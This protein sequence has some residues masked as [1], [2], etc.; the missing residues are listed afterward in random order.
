MEASQVKKAVEAL[1]DYTEKVQAQ[2]KKTALLDSSD[3]ISVQF[4]F[5]TIPE[6]ATKKPT[7]IRLPHPL[8]STDNDAKVCLIVKDPQRKVKDILEGQSKES[9]V[10]KVLGLSKLRKRY[11]QYDDKKQLCASYDVFLADEAV[12][13]MLAQLTGKAFFSCKKMPIPIDMRTKTKLLK[14]IE[15]ARSSTVFYSGAG[16]CSSVKAATTE[17]APEQ[18]AENIEGVVAGVVDATPQKWKNI[19]SIHVKTH[20]SVALPLYDSNASQDGSRKRGADGEEG[21]T[22][23]AKKKRRK[24]TKKA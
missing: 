17:F 16:A 7:M 1:L 13:P 15:S 2:S 23:K 9:N 12:Q 22:G 11:K 6:R 3:P 21:G 4:A 19:R 24:S 14:A 20:N 10:D 8:Y 18:I 5:K